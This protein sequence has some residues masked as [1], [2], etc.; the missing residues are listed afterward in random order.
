[1][2]NYDSAL[3]YDQMA[4]KIFEEAGDKIGIA[5]NLGNI[6]EVYYATKIQT[7]IIRNLSAD[8]SRLQTSDWQ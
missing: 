8:T 3:S 1:M 7:V 5:I 6:G 4:L 2:R